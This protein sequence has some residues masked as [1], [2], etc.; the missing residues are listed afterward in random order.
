M[1]GTS[2]VYRP[3][4]NVVW[5]YGAVLAAPVMWAAVAFGSGEIRLEP[6]PA[7]GILA[8]IPSAGFCFG[9]RPRVKV[10]PRSVKVVNPFVCRVL[11]YEDIKK[12]N[13]YRV[14]VALF[15]RG[16]DIVSPAAFGTDKFG[17]LNDPGTAEAMVDHVNK[18]VNLR[19]KGALADSRQVMSRRR[20]DWP[21]VAAAA[22]PFVLAALTSLA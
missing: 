9:I 1:T 16:T 8:L 14:T 13:V 21:S 18:M 4:A 11:A 10:S 7:M 5:G 3:G 19:K 12:A 2:R 17:R 20:P 6:H 15:L 22:A